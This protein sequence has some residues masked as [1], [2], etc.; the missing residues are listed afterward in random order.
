MDRTGKMVIRIG[1]LDRDE[2]TKFIADGNRIDFVK[3][4]TQFYMRQP[5]ELEISLTLSPGTIPG[6]SLG[7][8]TWGC[9][10]VD[11]WLYL[12]GNSEAVD[13]LVV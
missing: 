10:G 9:L 1:P 2:Y 11:S 13:M 3:F 8:E 6:I 7:D 12:D 4:V 5:L